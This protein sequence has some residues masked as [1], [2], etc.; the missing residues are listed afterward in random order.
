MRRKFI[1]TFVAL[2][3]GVYMASYAQE[4]SITNEETKEVLVD[5][6][7]YDDLYKWIESM[8]SMPLIRIT[9]K[10]DPQNNDSE[11]IKKLSKYLYSLSN[12]CPDFFVIVDMSELTNLPE[13]LVDSFYGNTCLVKAVISPSTKTIGAEA[14]CECTHL[15]EV[16]F[17]DSVTCIER[18]AFKKCQSLKNCTLPNHLTTIGDGVFEESGLSTLEIPSSVV[19]IGAEIISGTN[20]TS[21]TIPESVNSLDPLV[22]NGSKVT[23]LTLKCRFSTINFG[24]TLK[25]QKVILTKENENDFLISH[26]HSFPLLQ[27]IEY[28]DGTPYMLKFTHQNGLWLSDDGTSLCKVDPE[29]HSVTIP[30]SVTKIEANA[31]LD[32]RYLTSVTL[33]PSLTYI[34][35]YAFHHD[36]YQSGSKKSIKIC[37]PE[38]CVFIACNAFYNFPELKSVVFKDSAGWMKVIYKESAF[39]NIDWNHFDKTMLSPD[40]DYY[41]VNVGTKRKA[42]KLV[43][44]KSINCLIKMQ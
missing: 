3:V 20:I 5:V 11:N 30:L 38:S 22:L 42:E 17:S 25:V 15:N 4:I 16:V 28:E 7:G 2:L 23:T 33:P 14:F 18:I 8:K 21:L 29:I 12:R 27:T 32:C 9:L 43:T 1:V 13:L 44:E 19:T 31:F 6:T 36:T 24:N 34:G 39:K 35:S 10:N 40:L 41:Q 37:I 26:L